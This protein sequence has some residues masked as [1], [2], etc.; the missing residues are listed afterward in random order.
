MSDSKTIAAL[1]IGTGKM[2]V[3]IGEIVDNKMLNLVGVGQ[4]ATDGVKKSRYNRRKESRRTGAGSNSNG[5]ALMLGAY[6]IRVSRHK[7]HAYSGL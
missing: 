2:Q 7:R 5:G 6:K 4:A 1:E 3:F